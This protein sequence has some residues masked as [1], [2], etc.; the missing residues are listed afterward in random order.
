LLH[1]YHHTTDH[2]PPNRYD[3]GIT[4]LESDRPINTK[5]KISHSWTEAQAIALAA[6]FNETL[7]QLRHSSKL[8]NSTTAS[9]I[10]SF[11]GVSRFGKGG[12]NSSN[13]LDA[14]SFHLFAELLETTCQRYVEEASNGVIYCAETTLMA[15]KLLQRALFTAMAPNM[16]AILPLSDLW[17]GDSQDMTAEKQL[18][19]LSPNLIQIADNVVMGE[20]LPNSSSGAHFAYDVGYN[21]SIPDNTVEYSLVSVN[22]NGQS[23]VQQNLRTNIQYADVNP[24]LR[25]EHSIADL[26]KRLGEGDTADHHNKL[27]GAMVYLVEKNLMLSQIISWQSCSGDALLAFTGTNGLMV[28]LPKPVPPEKLRLVPPTWF[29]E[30]VIFITPLVKD[31][32]TPLRH[33]KDTCWT[34]HRGKISHQVEEDGDTS[35]FVV[36]VGKKEYQVCGDCICRHA[37]IPGPPGVT[38]IPLHPRKEE[39]Q[40]DGPDDKKEENAEDDK[41]E[42][43]AEDEGNPVDGR[44][45]TTDGEEAASEQNLCGVQQPSAEPPDIHSCIPE[46]QITMHKCM[47]CWTNT[48]GKS[49]NSSPHCDDVAACPGRYNTPHFSGIFGFPNINRSCFCNAAMQMLMS[50]DQFILVTADAC[51]EYEKTNGS[52]Q[53][54]ID[55]SIQMN[56]FHRLA[57]AQGL[58]SCTTHS[59]ATEN[60][61]ETIKRDVLS[62]MYQAHPPLIIDHDSHEFMT[63]FFMNLWP[64]DEWMKF[65]GAKTIRTIS[66]TKCK[67]YVTK[68]D[69]CLF[70]PCFA[71]AIPMSADPTRYRKTASN[72]PTGL[73]TFT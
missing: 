15:T 4:L 6:L 28:H 66:C 35:E 44:D 19:N 5:S 46:Q 16:K 29:D 48:L 51:P 14:E 21:L 59:T 22:E 52:T 18:A 62:S 30:S 53:H 45:D 31:P 11:T 50:I 71:S 72:I 73:S 41:K 63:N 33:S 70:L 43:T 25:Y 17:P 67:W 68:L 12:I 38:A 10:T 3:I 27:V 1:L 34:L 54:V 49:R 8:R 23:L 47:D 2:T 58:D 55:L 24:N 57:I 9:N 69:G 40:D 64:S 13:Q 42:E 7:K 36:K 56:K 26:L 65:L 20:L 61:L 39:I 32:I 60:I 37:G